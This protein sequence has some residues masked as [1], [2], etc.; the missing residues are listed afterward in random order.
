LWQNFD[1]FAVNLYNASI[2]AAKKFY[3][4]EQGKNLAAKARMNMILEEIRAVDDYDKNL[5]NDLD[6]LHTGSKVET[7][8]LKKDI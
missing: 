7:E 6:G 8:Q 3:D 4:K 1:R 2:S 5:L